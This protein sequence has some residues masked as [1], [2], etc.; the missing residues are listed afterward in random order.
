M[1]NNILFLIEVR[2][3]L[4]D[5]DRITSS[6]SSLF[7]NKQIIKCSGVKIKNTGVIIFAHA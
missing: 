3:P 7:K 1:F 6:F 2:L 5:L 4:K